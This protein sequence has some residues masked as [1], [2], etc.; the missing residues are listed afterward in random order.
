MRHTTA[1]SMDTIN[2]AHHLGPSVPVPPPLLDAPP[3]VAH[4]LERV[5]HLPV[6]R[7]DREEVSVTP[8]KQLPDHL[9][10]LFHRL[11]AHHVTRRLDDEELEATVK[12]QP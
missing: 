6:S 11:V 8:I 1:V 4:L 10:D 7:V 3:L 5:E 9:G 12:G 2:H